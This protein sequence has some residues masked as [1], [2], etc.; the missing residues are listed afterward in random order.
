MFWPRRVNTEELCQLLS[1]TAAVLPPTKKQ[2]KGQNTH[3]ICVLFFV[4]GANMPAPPANTEPHQCKRSE[5]SVSTEAG[6]Q[7]LFMSD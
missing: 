1:S 6:G 7:V 5:L 3:S 2:S 4:S